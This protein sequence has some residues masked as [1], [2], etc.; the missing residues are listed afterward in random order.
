L[1]DLGPLLTPRGFYLGDGTAV[2]LHLGHRRFVDLD[3]FCAQGM[4]DPLELAHELRDDGVPFVTGQIARGTLHGT[5]RGVQVSLLR[6]RY[7][8]LRQPQR[9]PG[10]AR[11]AALLDL[12]AMKL[13]AVAQRGS[14]KDFVDI[15]A[16]GSQRFPLRRMLR[17]YQVKYDTSDIAHVQYSLTYFADADSERMPPMLWAVGWKEVKRTITDWVAGLAR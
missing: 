16:I 7:R 14:K 8:L 15:F 3:W 1:R 6:Y 5:V 4:S 2:A 17:H 11:I 10:E 13:A 9:G 12:A